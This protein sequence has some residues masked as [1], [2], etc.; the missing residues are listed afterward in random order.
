MVPVRLA[1]C[2]QNSDADAVAEVH[3]FALAQRGLRIHDD[4][5]RPRPVLQVVLDESVSQDRAGVGAVAAKIADVCRRDEQQ[6]SR[7]VHSK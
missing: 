2:H 3:E 7:Q 5:L 1:W 6:V 4:P